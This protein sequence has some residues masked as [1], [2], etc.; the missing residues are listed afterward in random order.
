LKSLSFSSVK[1]EDQP[2]F[3]THG[4]NDGAMNPT[5]AITPGKAI[6][7]LELDE[8]ISEREKVRSPLRLT[9]IMTAL[10]V[11][12]YPLFNAYLINIGTS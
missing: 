1:M 2:R 3:E 4:N 6:E 12:L 9:A 11:R 8:D 5:L 10:Y 7:I